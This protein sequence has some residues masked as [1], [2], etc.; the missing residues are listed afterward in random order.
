MKYQL[1]H[2]PFMLLETA[3]MVSRYVNHFSFNS[4]LYKLKLRS[5]GNV[6]D[7]R[8]RVLKRLQEILEELCSGLNREDPR[9]RKFF[10]VDNGESEDLCVAH[11]MI[12]SFFTLNH[13]DLRESAR[14]ICGRWQEVQERGC[15]LS[16]ETYSFLTLEQGEGS[17]G[18]LF[19]QIS[20]MRF[21]TDFQMKLY[22][23]LRRFDQTMA[24]LV[25]ILEPLGKKLEDIYR[26]ESWLFDAVEEDWQEVFQKQ[27]PLEFMESF[28]G[29]DMPWDAHKELRVAISLM[30]A[31]RM[32]FTDEREVPFG[33]PY[34]FLCIGCG[35]PT[36]RLTRQR[37]GDFDS[38]AATLRFLGDR[39]RLEILRRL[40]REPSYGMELADSL[41]MD[42]GN[43]SRTLSQLHKRGFLKQEREDSRLYYR[44]DR[45]S[46]ISFLKMVEHM[47]L[48]GKGQIL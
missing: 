24:E 32:L 48:T 11:A 20:A 39:K 17:P 25:E 4:V 33:L 45:E 5:E 15:W 10:M 27:P 37:E 12:V 9:L 7:K 22:G 44:T 47:V 34:E 6:S 26:Q 23:A 43:M 38:V 8:I 46:R 1:V 19:D 30:Y 31:N 36:S 3:A 2:G 28:L 41:G 35:V 29:D 14:E 42:S 16:P 13:A 18:D 21:S 40:D